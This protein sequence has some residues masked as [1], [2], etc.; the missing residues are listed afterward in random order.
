MPRILLV[1]EESPDC[2]DLALNL[3]AEGFEVCA[4][5]SGSESL[6]LAGEQ[7]PD[8]L[9]LN[10]QLPGLDNQA[11]RQLLHR[12]AAAPILM[13]QVGEAQIKGDTEDQI[14]AGLL[15][16]IHALLG[17]SSEDGSKSVTS[18]TAG[19]LT[20]DLISRRVLRGNVP[21]KLTQKEFDLLAELMRHQG[22][23][24]SRGQ[25][26]TRVWGWGRHAAEGSHTVDV[27]IRWLREK[28]EANP[29]VPARI[30][31]VRGAGYRFE[32]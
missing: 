17:K 7:P 22:Q 18:L 9:I 31:T 25:L 5:P 8:L 1:D 21:L 29:S 26:L 16:R 28:V 6:R 14:S 2:E 3:R 24:L 12:C 10:L 15:S 11:L 4:A 13:R 23:V 27:H 20:L 19:D 32:S 30:V